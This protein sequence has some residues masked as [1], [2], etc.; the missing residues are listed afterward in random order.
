MRY[1]ERGGVVGQGV[2]ESDPY[3]VVVK[4]VLGNEILVR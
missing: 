3:T 4:T 1:W 2:M